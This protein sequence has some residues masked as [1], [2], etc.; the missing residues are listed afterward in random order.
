MSYKWIWASQII[1]KHCHISKI[2]SSKCICKLQESAKVLISL[3]Q[4]HWW[5]KNPVVGRNWIFT[6]YV[7]ESITEQP[8]VTPFGHEAIMA[9]KHFLHYWLLWGVH[10]SPVDSLPSGR[11][12]NTEIQRCRGLIFVNLNELFNKQSTCQW[13]EM[14]QSSCDVPVM[15]CHDSSLGSLVCFTKSSLNISQNFVKTFWF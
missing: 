4:C 10:Q 15:W 7:S 13:F 12:S 2:L 3:K 1:W 5:T 9:W 14:I 8:W 11:V 6:R